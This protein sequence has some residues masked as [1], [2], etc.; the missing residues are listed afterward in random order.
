MSIPTEA[1]PKTPP[2]RLKSHEE[3]VFG[4]VES[5]LP[6]AE[7][8]LFKTLVAQRRE[9]QPQIQDFDYP[10]QEKH[11][12]NLSLQQ[13]RAKAQGNTDLEK[14]FYI[15]AKIFEALLSEIMQ[16]DWFPDFFL[17]ETSEFD[18]RINGV[19]AVLESQAHSGRAA[20]IDFTSHKDK[21][22]L[23]EKIQK[24]FRKIE[25]GKLG[26]VKYFKSQT[27]GQAHHLKM[28]PMV[29]IG[30]DSRTLTEIIDIYTAQSKRELANHWVKN[31]IVEELLRQIAAFQKYI[32][33]TNR[34]SYN[35]ASAKVM[36][37]AYEDFRKMVLELKQKISQG[38]ETDS[39]IRAGL[40]TK[41]QVY[42]ELTESLAF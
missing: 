26:E 36:N 1:L 9:K 8:Q 20:L 25:Q 18:D 3:A 17:T 22:K 12:D 27:D 28:L 7:I 39:R 10:E 4:Q 15:R 6:L 5:R 23:R 37:Q 2:Q 33:S 14:L 34:S 35:P 30:L 19:D 16:R 24:I 38:E 32:N 41:D 31:A 11:K 21:Q 42:K 40:P 13:A 29:I